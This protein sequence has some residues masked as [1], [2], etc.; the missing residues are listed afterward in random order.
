MVTVPRV[1]PRSPRD[2]EA[3][4][5]G[6]VPRSQGWTV[7]PTLAEESPDL[8]PHP[9]LPPSLTCVS[10]NPV[11]PPRP[12]TGSPPVSS[13]TGPPLPLGTGDRSPPRRHSESKSRTV[14]G[15]LERRERATPISY[16]T[17][18]DTVVVGVRSRQVMLPRAGVG[19]GANVSF[20]PRV[21]PS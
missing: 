15:P 17:S 4:E 14:G 2:V 19:G 3:S 6:G 12:R 1:S 11:T 8:N 13:P 21:P 9:K 5:S 7:T 18:G 20:R 16:Q 10:D